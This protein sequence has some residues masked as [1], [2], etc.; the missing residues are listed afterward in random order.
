M[1]YYGQLFYS[2]SS[3]D[4][5]MVTFCVTR[6]TNADIKVHNVHVHKMASYYNVC[7]IIHVHYAL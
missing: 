4:A 2:K 7:A 5:W 6:N 3:R 1:E